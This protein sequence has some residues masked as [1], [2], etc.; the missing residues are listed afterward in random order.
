MEV[1]SH[2]YPA[3]KIAS[4]A[5]RLRRSKRRGVALRPREQR[6][7]P[8]TAMPQALELRRT[9]VACVNSDSRQNGN[10]YAAD[11]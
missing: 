5:R 9:S 1:G 8:L 6:N 2:R 4:P 7:N 3:S 10:L 11:Q